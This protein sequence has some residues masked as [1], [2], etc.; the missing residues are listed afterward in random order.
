MNET[1]ASNRLPSLN[2]LRTFEA[3]A[4][5]GSVTSAALELCV[6]QGAVSHQVALL[7][8]WFGRPLLRREG[9][10][11]RPSDDGQ[12]LSKHLAE[13]F[14]L[15]EEGCA[16]LRASRGD[17]PQIAAPASF[18]GNWLVP[19]LGVFESIHPGIHLRLRTDGSFEDL[20]ARIVDALV[21]CGSPPWP[22]DL[23]LFPFAT[24][25][26]GMVCSPA[27]ASLAKR[28]ASTSIA[29]LD[30]ASR[31]NAWKEWSSATGRRPPR[32]TVR[33]FDHL[34]PLLEAARS[35]LGVA[36]APELLVEREIQRG[37]LVAPFGF[38]E[39]ANQFALAILARRA[40]EPPLKTIAAWFQAS[41]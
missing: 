13:A 14:A 9:R 26:I 2:A 24:E 5:T 7:E 21:V 11:V 31:P 6:T 41:G 40:D 23:S 8:D 1:H 25:R 3:V 36:I 38:V 19:R 10:G 20:R 35:G 33:R 30:V 39:S 22:S 32:G 37:E 27:Q 34:A 15:L 4:R 29:R 28:G 12:E 16:K 18:L 17:E